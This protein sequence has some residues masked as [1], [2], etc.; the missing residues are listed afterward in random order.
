MKKII[1]LFQR[2]YERDYEGSRLV[3]NE[4]VT[5]AEWVANGEG[6]ATIKYDGTCCLISGR[7]FYKRYDRKLTKSNHR[8]LRNDSDYVPKVEDYKLAPPG[9]EAA[10][11]NPNLHT[12]HWPGWIPIG[13][14]PEDKWHR[15]AWQ[16]Y[17]EV[18]LPDGTR[19]LVGPKIQGNPYS[20]STHRLWTHDVSIRAELGENPPRDFDGLKIWLSKYEIEGI[21]WHHSD[22]RMVKIKRSDFGFP[23]PIKQAGDE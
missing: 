22:G 8:R 6:I 16:S 17:L 13:D 19:E 2:D 5:G 18:G 10:E 15:E 14:G 12:G 7:K 20:L 1:S 23:W 4:L 3:F 21:V 9:W 11:V